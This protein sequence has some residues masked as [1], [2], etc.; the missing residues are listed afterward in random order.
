MQQETKKGL[1]SID[2]NECVQHQKNQ[3][4]SGDL[5]VSRALTETEWKSDRREPIA[6]LIVQ[7]SSAAQAL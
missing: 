4:Q 5:R 7:H 1:E 6:T 3:K 2:T